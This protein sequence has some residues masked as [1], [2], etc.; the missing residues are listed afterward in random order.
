LILIENALLE[1]LVDSGFRRVPDFRSASF[2]AQSNLKFSDAAPGLLIGST[3][4]LAQ[5]D[6][7]RD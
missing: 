1:A 2:L 7:W 4:V 3:I 5:G 6:F